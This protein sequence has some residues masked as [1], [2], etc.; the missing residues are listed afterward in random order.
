MSCRCRGIRHDVVDGSPESLEQECAAVEVVAQQARAAVAVGEA[1]RG[2][3]EGEIALSPWNADLEDSRRSVSE[4]RLDD[5]RR[6][7]AAQRG[8]DGQ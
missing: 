6:V 2:R 5:E 1:Q 8:A 4:C 3:L 7:A